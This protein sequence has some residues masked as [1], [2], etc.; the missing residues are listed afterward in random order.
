MMTIFNQHFGNY[1]HSLTLLSSTVAVLI[2]L[3][4]APALG[5]ELIPFP[6]GQQEQRA[7]DP[8]VFKEFRQ[9]IDK[10]NCASL[11]QIQ[12]DLIG[13]YPNCKNVAEKGYYER[14]IGIVEEV[15]SAKGCQ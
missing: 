7:V 10:L 4:G 13:K 5:G 9:K 8:R 2:A 14:L 1:A 15:K 6:S 11:E 12:K 3:T